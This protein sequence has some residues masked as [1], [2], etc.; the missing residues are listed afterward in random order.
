MKSHVKCDDLSPIAGMQWYEY[1]LFACTVMHVLC[2]TFQS[3]TTQHGLNSFVRGPDYTVID[4]MQLAL[5]ILFT[6]AELPN[7]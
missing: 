5:L 1:F 3:G 7:K 2:I 4:S 6:C